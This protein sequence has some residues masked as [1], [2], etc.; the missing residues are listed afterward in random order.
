[1]EQIKIGY[2]KST[3]LYIIPNRNYFIINGN[4]E[5]PNTIYHNN[6]QVLITSIKPA[7]Y[8]TYS[9]KTVITKYEKDNDGTPGYLTVEE[10]NSYI[11]GLKSKGRED[12]YDWFFDE[13]EDEIKYKRFLKDWQSRSKQEET[14]TDYEIVFVEVPISEYED[15][16]PLAS[17]ADIDSCAKA[18]FIYKPNP[19]KYLSEYCESLG[20]ISESNEYKKTPNSYN[21]GP[22]SNIDY[23]KINGEYIFLG[24]NKPRIFQKIAKYQ[25][26]IDEMNQ[27]IKF[28]KDS[29][30]LFLRKNDKTPLTNIE[31]GSYYKTLINIKSDIN[32][33]EVNKKHHSN[34]SSL[35]NRIQKLI[36]SIKIE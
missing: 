9:S 25:E 18:L 22:H 10:Y 14:I 34:Q 29:V 24:D 19:K 8:Q 33:L 6:S 32:G 26:C 20:M 12:D 11:L 1:M 5:K 21:Y 28:I 15:I 4:R 35:I 13:L 27:H 30:D 23:A 2:D 36:E 31:R 17:M 16:Q 3:G 7:S